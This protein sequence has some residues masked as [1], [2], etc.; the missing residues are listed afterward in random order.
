MQQELQNIHSLIKKTFQMKIQYKRERTR[1]ESE[2]EPLSNLPEY[3]L[4][5]PPEPTRSG[6]I[7]ILMAHCINEMNRKT[8]YVF[9][10]REYFNIHSITPELI[11]ELKQAII[12]IRQLINKESYEKHVP[13]IKEWLDNW[14]EVKEGTQPKGLQCLPEF[15]VDRLK[16]IHS[17]LIKGK[18][19]KCSEED[20]LKT[21]QAGTFD[22]LPLDWTGTNPELATLILRLTGIN[23]T[24]SIVNLYFKP[25]K[26][27]DSHSKRGTPDNHKIKLLIK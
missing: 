27:Y 26:A 2:S 18:L 5:E 22:C 9:D 17:K 7:K 10:I 16:V 15:T 11:P 23:P 8:G 19:L 25:K 12:E 21:F 3:Y 13:L 20:F 24:P 6:E 1:S 14:K 4:T